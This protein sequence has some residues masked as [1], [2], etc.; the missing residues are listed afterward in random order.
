LLFYIIL[1]IEEDCGAVETFVYLIT[2]IFNLMFAFN[3]NRFIWLT[4]SHFYTSS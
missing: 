3:S 4:T 2:C 1:F